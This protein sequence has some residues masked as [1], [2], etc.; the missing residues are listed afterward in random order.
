MIQPV[1]AKRYQLGQIIRSDR[2]TVLRQ[3]T[4]TKTEM[5]V[6][7][8]IYPDMNQAA[9]E[10][11]L[12]FQRK[13]ELASRVSHPN[14]LD[15]LSHD[16]FNGTPYVVYEAIENETLASRIPKIQNIDTSIEMM[17][18]MTSAI[19]AMHQ[20]S[21]LHG[22]I[23]PGH[24]YFNNADIL[25]IGGLGNNL[26]IDLTSVTRPEDVVS[27]FGYLSP[28][29]SGILR[30]PVD[31]RSDIYSLGILFYELLT[32]R[33][34]YDADEMTTLIHQHIARRP[35]PPATINNNIPAVIEEM[36]LRLIEKEPQSR[37]QT[38]SALC[39]DLQE[40]Q[41]RQAKGEKAI[42]FQIARRDRLKTLS[43]HTR[44]IGRDEEINHLKHLVD[45]C[46]RSRGTLCL[47]YGEAG[48]GK[49]RLIDEI[50]GYV[51]ARGDLFLAGK[52]SPYESKTPYRVFSIA[53][54]AYVE[55]VKRMSPEKQTAIKAKMNHTIGKLG[56][57]IVKIAP[58]VVDLL[59]E[60]PELI[61]LEPE[62][63]KTRFLVTLTNFILALGSP[64]SPAVIFL[65]DMQWCDKES[66][67][68]LKII[69]E[70]IV[71]Q[72]VL[73]IASF[74][75]EE[76]DDDHPL[77]HAIQQ[78]Q[79]KTAPLVKI[80]L[81]RFDIQETAQ[82]TAQILMENTEAVLPLA[83]E[84]TQR[85]R[86]NPFF[87][88]EIL[89]SL[90]DAGIIYLKDH[91][92]QYDIDSVKEAV[93]PENVI[94]MVINRIENIAP[95]NRTILSY[96]SV[97][98]NAIQFQLLVDTVRQ[99]HEIVLNAVEAGIS[100]QLLT[101]DVTGKET[102]Y[103]SHDRIH[104]AFYERLSKTEKIPL[105]EHI[106][107]TLEKGNV[108]NPEPVLLDLAYHF[109]KAE[110]TDK[111]LYYSR[112]AAHM[113]RRAHSYQ[114]ALE[115]YTT[116]RNILAA[117][118]AQHSEE[119]LEIL[120]NLG[121][122]YRVIGE[123]DRSM[124]Y[125]QEAEQ[126]VA[127]NDL[128]RRVHI[129]SLQSDTLWHN[130]RLEESIQT[131]KDIL[132]LLGLSCPDS[133]TTINA[134]L[135]WQFSI[136]MAHI[137]L[138]FIFISS[139]YR[140]DQ[141]RIVAVNTLR[142]LAHIYFFRDIKTA[143]YY[144]FRWLNLIEKTGPSK[145]LA[146]AYIS[147]IA[148]WSVLPWFGR[149]RKY[150]K[151]GVAIAEE[152]NDPLLEGIGYA[153]Y[154][155]LGCY[156]TNNMSQ[157]HTY[158]RKAIKILKERGEFMGLGVAFSFSDQSSMLLGRF[159]EAKIENTEFIR[160]LKQVDALQP[161][162]W[163]L[164]NRALL[165]VLYEGPSDK[166][167]DLI[168]ESLALKQQTHDKTSVMH[169]KCILSL[170]LLRKNE[171]NKAIETVEESIK[172]FRRFQAPWTFNDLTIAAQIYVDSVSQQPELDETT[173]KHYLKRAGCFI[174]KAS[175]VSFFYPFFRGWL[176]QV[177]GTYHWH[178][179]RKHRAYKLWDKGLRWLHNNKGNPGGDKYRIASILLE[180]ATFLL[181]D[182]P[183]NKTAHQHIIQARDI[184]RDLGCTMDLKRATALLE[185]VSPEETLDSRHALT[186]SRHL[187]SLL[188]VTQ[189]IGSIFDIEALLT[190]IM[191]YA[192]QTTGAERGFLFLYETDELVLKNAFPP[193]K[194]KR[195]SYETFK[196]SYALITQVEERQQA[197]IAGCNTHTPDSIK[198][199]LARYA[200]KQVMCVHLKAKETS[201]GIIYLDSSLAE[202][203][204]GREELALMQ[205]FAVQASISIENAYLYS[206]LESMVEKQ[207][208]QLRD[209]Q[210]QLIDNAHQAGMA[211]IAVGVLHNVGN[212]LNSV[213]T[214]IHAMHEV[215]RRSKGFEG[216]AR[217]NQMLREK[218][219]VIDDFIA[220]DPKGKT[221]L[222][223]YLNIG[224]IL[225][226]NQ[227]AIRGEL[228]RLTEKIE[229]ITNIITAQ[230]RYAS[231]GGLSEKQDIVAIAND[232]LAMQEESLKRRSIEVTRIFDPVP[233]IMADKTK[234]IHVLIN[235]IQN[236]TDALAG[237]NGKRELRIA[238]TSQNGT[239]RVA[240]R[241]NGPGI[242]PHH[243]EK[244]FAHGY[245]TKPEGHG[246]GL[247]TSANYMTEMGGRMWAESDGRGKGS[248]FILAFPTQTGESP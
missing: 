3:A 2:L 153:Y 168:K 191:A 103:F 105:H 73:I 241:D 204:F 185:T 246:F 245:T 161:L 173:R 165:L 190:E 142:K 135:L 164:S 136:Q 225:Q 214:S 200:I 189:A 195:F 211:D 18:Q 146:Y 248:T 76:V 162:G 40:Y 237:I 160:I 8:A 62:K 111:S 125:L 134:G 197:Y 144:M 32:G 151:K 143:V 174:R 203:M 54:T 69:S 229:V 139:K 104:Q 208:R 216:I 122:L 12:Q 72:A 118:N 176:Y 63:E 33:L 53:I 38:L 35:A 80:P 107:N 75:D 26:L 52:Y 238:I 94:E 48:M 194:E 86:G 42:S 172:Q 37:Y 147:V 39:D 223:Y 22:H 112:L 123:F 179:G 178:N 124:Q 101:W 106:G 115:L 96:A 155:A 198:S 85:S 130:G 113:A 239:V 56:G 133:K 20:N 68:L 243:L 5:P 60:P 77:A 217:A 148:F 192:I 28:E 188:S 244:I 58:A 66:I 100:Q 15:I 212:V 207:T 14:L 137:A 184:F 128:L 181:M 49:S 44:L 84:L 47:V 50:R 74:R 170:A 175:A 92:Y 79:A 23:R 247:H 132:K 43:Y 102:F 7:L 159:A 99:P 215:L 141:K 36:V 67:E 126:L 119:Y 81:N 90:V 193:V 183:G 71:D 231:A 11:Q 224:D 222:H 138:P 17:H 167:F 29:Q 205:S 227:K 218:M 234:L 110:M 220:N 180:K 64:E 6:A 221:L 13:I 206:N 51:H 41:H 209:A 91:H 83:E 30:S 57:E 93:L 199:E 78:L 236:A 230:Q 10:R 158:T 140:Q 59:G 89:H 157:A 121:E 87:L 149:V 182:F 117:R 16:E 19:E 131:L 152:I 109:T 196:I 98:G 171:F 82:V 25:K 88:I 114:T 108:A 65:D 145:E 70:N 129:L 95:E 97:M 210:Q 34:P 55:K 235:I 233:A 166:L 201:S 154:G 219:S 169:T 116:A 127:D 226:D 232:A 228:D 186:Q 31:H 187:Q 9:L 213:R 45:E 4:D 24:I 150:F 177:R 240:A 163:I 202:G 242:T 46:T 21:I 120:E 61:T 1:F 27:V 156:L